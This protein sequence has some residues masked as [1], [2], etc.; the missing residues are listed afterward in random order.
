MKKRGTTD[1]TAKETPPEV[2]SAQEDATNEETTPP[3]METPPE[4]GKDEKCS[5]LNDRYLRLYADFDNYRKRV[6]REKDDLRK[7]GNESLLFEL[8][9]IIDNLELALRHGACEPKTG[10]MQGVEITL[11]EFQRVLEKFGLNRIPAEGKAFDP[12]FHHAMSQIERDDLDEKMVAEE[13]RPG[14]LYHGKVLRPALV[15][16]SIRPRKAEP[17]ADT[18]GEEDP[19]A[20]QT[21]AKQNIEEEQ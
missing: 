4:K 12:A 20:V 6:N 16:V 17:E 13:F 11:K 21:L 19:E 7:Y 5:D 8:L 14:Y 9:P 3:D 10:L 1:N 18:G 2:L 15:G